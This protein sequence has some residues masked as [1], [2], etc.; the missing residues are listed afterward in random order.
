MVTIGQ[1][2]IDAGTVLGLFFKSGPFSQVATFLVTVGS[3]LIAGQGTIGP[4]TIG[5]IKLTITVSE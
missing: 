4:I 5:S 1:Y 3:A 2:F